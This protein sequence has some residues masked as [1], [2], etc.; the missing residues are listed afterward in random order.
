MLYFDILYG[1]CILINKKEKFNVYNLTDNEIRIKDL[2]KLLLHNVFKERKLKI[3]YVK[4]KE[5]YFRTEFTKTT[6]SNN[7][8]KKLDGKN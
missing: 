2:A 4:S 5:K 7:K 3:T 1:I 6:V 8:I